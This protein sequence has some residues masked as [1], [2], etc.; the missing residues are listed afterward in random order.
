MGYTKIGVTPDGS[1]TYFLARMIGL[2]RAKE[3]ALLNPVLSAEQAME[4][5]FINQVVDDEL[6]MSTSLEIAKQLAQGPTR[7]YGETKRLIL[8]GA[9]ESLETQMEQETRSIAMFA[10]SKDGLEGIAAFSEKRSPVFVGV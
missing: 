9:N 5:G 2:R 8:R 3:L 4:W 1:S 6:V 7:A 10:D